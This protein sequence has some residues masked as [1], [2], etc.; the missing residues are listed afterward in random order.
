MIEIDETVGE[1]AASWVVRLGSDQRT[2]ADE[3]AFRSWMEEDP[4]H[5]QAF[6]DCT[7]L[8]DGVRH[9]A[10]SDDGH[11]ALRPLRTPARVIGRVTRR[12]AVFGGTGAVAAAAAG[13]A[14]FVVLGR[15]QMLQTMPGEQK[16]VRLADGTGV[17]LNTDSRLRVKLS[18]SERRLYLD[19]G[20]AFFQVAKDRD[21][22]FRVFAGRDEV[23]ALGTAFEVRRVGSDV[24]VTLEEGRVAIYRDGNPR[25]EPPYKSGRRQSRSLP[26]AALTKV[27]PAVVLTPGE[28]AWV[29]SA[30][31]VSVR[32]VDL[33]KVQAWRY[34]R[35]ILDDATLGETVVDLNRY[36]GV[37]I[38]LADPKLASIRV[39]GV[40]HTGRPDDFVD[41]VTS[42]FPVEIARQDENTIVL[43]PH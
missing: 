26:E 13:I 11:R 32:Q 39:S 3:E 7:A 25:D 41:A 37:Q 1:I 42:A 18:K 15:E 23:R 19:R 28:Q 8:W 16:R 27:E 36:G 12:T 30:E 40:F 9:L 20:Q 33:R 31:P 24:L 5:A 29:R 35:M 22:P 6:A 43:K 4:A 14:A 2:R 34:G 21:R 17:L 38:I 10:A